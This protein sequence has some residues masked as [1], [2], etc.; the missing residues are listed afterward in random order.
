MGC[1][2]GAGWGRCSKMWV[3]EGSSVHEGAGARDTQNGVRLPRNPRIRH[4]LAWL[5]RQTR[6]SVFGTLGCYYR[7]LQSHASASSYVN[8]GPNIHCKRGY[9]RGVA[10][11]VWL[12]NGAPVLGLPKAFQLGYHSLRRRNLINTVVHAGFHLRFAQRYSLLAN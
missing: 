5:P 3:P 1:Q 12:H 8:S 10:P 11:L 9:I 2:L 6:Y 4:C 7:Q